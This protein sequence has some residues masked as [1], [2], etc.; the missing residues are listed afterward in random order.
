[1][2]K[3]PEAASKE[4][5]TPSS[6]GFAPQRTE[7]LLREAAD[8]T[9]APVWMTDQD[10][11][12]VFANRA[13]EESAGVP[14]DELLGNGWVDFLHPDDIPAVREKRAAAWADNHAA[15]VYEARFRRADGAWRTMLANARP[16][17]TADGRFQGYVGLAIDLTEM[18]AAEAAMRE[19]EARFRLLAESAPV[20]L[21]MG[22]EEGR[23]LY[24][25]RPL[26][27][28]WGVPEELGGF[29]WEATVVEADRQRLFAA[30]EM[31]M[32]R[33]EPLEVEAR[34]HRADGEIRTLF[35]RA[36]PRHDPEGRFLG[37]IGVNVDVTEARRAEEHQRLLIN[38]LNHRVKNSLA[39]VQ[40]IAHQTLRDGMPVGEARDLL[41]ARLLSLS[42]AHDVLTRES[43]EGADLGEVVAAALR[44]Y[45]AARHSALGPPHRVGP[46]TA[47][48]LSMAL[49]ELATNALKYG[50]L[51][52]AEG[53]VSVAWETGEDGHLVLTWR[54]EGG[55][56][57]VA[58]SRTGFGSRL[59]RQG[60]GVELGGPAD[61]RFE[62]TGLVCVIRARMA[63]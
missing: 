46:Q 26:R 17:T 34:Y 39:T 33:R 27:A 44:P 15:Y 16:R 62:P 11:A 18:R 6:E 13:F 51:S 5:R 45:D 31:A 43:W 9:P 2:L 35:T 54:E 12:M 30:M 63:A 3:R 4:P 10:G 57:V 56:P 48:A 40:S 55:P 23:C 58:P 61:L 42:A 59:L 32:A 21:W 7:P 24:L 60:L 41:T 28:F 8:C 52:G 38:E 20:M 19:S 50:A 25:N 14:V 1:M 53:K 47:L 37:M 29:S 22:D 36:E 49:H